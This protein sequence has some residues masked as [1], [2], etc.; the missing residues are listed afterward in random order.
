MEPSVIFEDNH[1][2]VV[3]KPAGLVVHDG[4]GHHQATL[5]DWLKQRLPKSQ[6]A[7]KRHGILHRLDK[8]TSGLLLIAKTPTAFTY[9]KRL[10][11]NRE[12]TKEYLVLVHGHLTPARGLIQIP[13]G[14]DIIHRTQ[15]E[16]TRQGRL[17][18]TSY[19]VEKVYRD[20][21]YLKAWPK[22]GRTHQIRVHFGSLGHP[23]VGDKVYGKTDTLSRQ[24]LHAHQLDFTD[25]DGTTRQ[26]ISPLP[27]D[28]KSFLDGLNK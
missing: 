8:D 25:L 17:A 18:E 11:A 15:F 4:A 3:D 22:T 26:F 28:L 27:S 19:Q 10:F 7:D 2:L 1:L 21:T 6:L 20:F 16:P 24:F 23:V 14:R 9:Y 5:V 12:I 13:L